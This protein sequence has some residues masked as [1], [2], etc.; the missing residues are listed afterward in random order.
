MLTREQ[1][2]V[3]EQAGV[4]VATLRL[5]AMSGAES[6]APILAY[7]DPR[8]IKRDVEVWLRAQHNRQRARAIVTGVAVVILVMAFA[9]GL[10]ELARATVL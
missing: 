8:P 6:E 9:C 3:V 4:E 2:E 7:A 1:Q 10:W 5:A